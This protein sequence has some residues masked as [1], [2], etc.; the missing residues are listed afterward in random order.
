[1]ELRDDGIYI[2]ESYV[3][4]GEEWTPLEYMEES[5]VIPWSWKKDRE[6]SYSRRYKPE[7]SPMMTMKIKRKFTGFK[8]M[9]IEGIGN[10]RVAIREE[11]QLRSSDKLN[12]T[13]NVIIWD[14][15]GLGLYRY[16]SK[17]EGYSY[18][19][20]FRDEISESEYNTFLG[21]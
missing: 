20:K 13:S 3:N 19:M 1:L 6:V 7:G 4:V 9:K 17:R 12:V 15:P 18:V 8:E 21:R 11:K 16:E 10:V 5:V 14:V 2:L